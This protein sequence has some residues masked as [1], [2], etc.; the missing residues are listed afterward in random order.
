MCPSSSTLE[1]RVSAKVNNIRSKASGLLGIGRANSSSNNG[2]AEY[3]YPA[4]SLCL[5]M[6]FEKTQ[7]YGKGILAAPQVSGSFYV[8]APSE[9][10]SSIVGEIA[11]HLIASPEAFVRPNDT[12]VVLGQGNHQQYLTIK[13]G[14]H[15]WE[16]TWAVLR[17]RDLHLQDFQRRTH[18]RVEPLNLDSVVRI[19]YCPQHEIGVEHAIHLIFED[20]SEM[21]AYADSEQQGYAW[22]DA[23]H[24]AVW[25]QPYVSAK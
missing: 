22:A 11:V 14:S 3:D 24:Q 13:L 18:S 9:A 17:N 15:C 8:V 7:H 16:R 6:L 12:P 19:E 20:D 5:E 4:V 2:G 21:I 10:G 23:V 25:N 1:Q